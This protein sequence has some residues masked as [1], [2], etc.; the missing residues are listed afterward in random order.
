MP[1]DRRFFDVDLGI[2]YT[3]CA[4][5]EAHVHQV[6]EEADGDYHCLMRELGGAIITEL[7]PEQAA[8]RTF[9]DESSDATPDK[10]V[11]VNTMKLGEWASSEY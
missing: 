5:D 7:T 11:P 10:R 2:S 6:L 3:I 8:T 1:D 9:W 4:R